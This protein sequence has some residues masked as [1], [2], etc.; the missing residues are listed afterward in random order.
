MKTDDFLAES[1]AVTEVPPKG[2]KAGPKGRWVQVAEY[3]K[4]HPGEV[5]RWTGTAYGGTGTHLRKEHGLNTRTKKVGVDGDK[6]IYEIYV[7]YGPFPDE[8]DEPRDEPRDELSP[9]EGLSVD[10][11]PVDNMRTWEDG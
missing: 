6:P 3:L 2:D 1:V 7:T 9:A 8:K 5:R 10:G 11:V 4:A